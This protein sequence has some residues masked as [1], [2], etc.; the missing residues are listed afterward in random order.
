M[1]RNAFLVSLVLASAA[2]GM[3]VICVNGQTPYV[4]P[5]AEKRFQNYVKDTVGPGAWAG[6]VAGAGF[7][8]A[9]ND[10]EEWGGKSKGFGKRLASNFGRNLIKNTITYSLDEALKL[11]SNYYRS[12][13]RGVSDRIKNALLSTVTARKPDGKRTV[14]IPRLVGTYSAGII[15]KETWYPPRYTWKDGVRSGTISLGTK[16][17]INLVKE[18]IR[19]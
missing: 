2:I 1:K 5:S 11:D 8:T 6:M 14:G 17:L 13:K 18:F 16:A 3:S 15:S 12:E 4:R 10:P 9:R 7:A 19:R